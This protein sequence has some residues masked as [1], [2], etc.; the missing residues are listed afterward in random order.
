MTLFEHLK[1]STTCELSVDESLRKKYSRDASIFEMKPEIVAIPKSVKEIKEIVNFIRENKKKYPHLSLTVRAGGTDMSGGSLTQSILIQTDKLNSIKKLGDGFVT[2]EPGL[3][4]RDLAALLDK[5]D[6]KYPPFP[7]SWRFCAIGGIVANNS[8]GEMTLQYGKTEDFVEKLN[9]I[10]E[11]GNEY[12]ITKL[13]K[14]QLMEKARKDSFEG[15][16]YKKLFKLFDKNKELI[17]SSRPN[18]SKN[19]TG[20]DIWRVW[21]GETFDLPKLFIGSQGTLGIVTEVT[22]RVVPKFQHA[23]LLII[24]LNDFEKIPLIVRIVQ[25]YKPNS[26][27]SY[28]NYTTNLALKYF[29]EF[30]KI[31]KISPAENFKLFLPD[32]KAAAMRKTPKLTLLVQ[33]ESNQ[34]SEIHENINKLTEDL[35]MLKDVSYHICKNRKEREKYWAIRHDSFKL[36]KERVKGK[37]AAPFI[38]DTIVPTEALPQFF[39]EIYKIFENQPFVFTIAGHIGNGNFHVFP[40]IDMSQKKERD[41]IWEISKKVFALTWKYKGV[42]SAEHNDGLVR[43]PYLKE[44]YGTKIYDIFLDIKNIFDSEGIFNPKKKVNVTLEYAKQF[45]MHEQIG[46]IDAY[47]QQTLAK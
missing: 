2:V 11:D 37:Y 29:Y 20:Y 22:L 15:E 7:S 34:W 25:Q 17:Q 33:F 47:S 44:Q 4:Y 23:G 12:E 40:L 10:L 39:L 6:L 27:E 32:L 21:D 41:K 5:H 36:L 14:E 28:D 19:S 30:A 46:T 26:F 38:D 1:Q 42:M 31:I 35:S 13:S 8:G 9:V 3:Y 18:V 24:K 16:L 43:A 45:V